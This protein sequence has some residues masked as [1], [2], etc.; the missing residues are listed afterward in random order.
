MLTR[1]WRMESTIDV[2]NLVLGASLMSA[3]WVFGF[4]TVE[5]AARNA[6][7]S[8]ALIGVAAIMALIAFAAW[9]EW[10]NLVLGLWVAISPWAL[11]FHLTISDTALRT[12]VALGLVVAVLAAVEL[13][14]THRTPPRITA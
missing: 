13:W 5:M 4:T 8:G 1:K 7:V 3:P 10:V 6:W 12:Q 2:I 14:M 9:E 11:S